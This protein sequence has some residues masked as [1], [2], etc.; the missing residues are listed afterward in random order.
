MDTPSSLPL[1]ISLKA[2]RDRL[3]ALGLIA[4]D[5]DSVQPATMASLHFTGATA[6]F[7]VGN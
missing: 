1:P 5:A 6:L 7:L 3:E 4:I 2:Q